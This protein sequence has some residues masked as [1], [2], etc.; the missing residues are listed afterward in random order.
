MTGFTQA[1][2][3]V[4]DTTDVRGLAEFYRHLLGL[5]YRPGDEPAAE[6]TPDDVDWLVLTEAVCRCTAHERLVR[7]VPLQ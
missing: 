5:Q 7:W 6:G 4:L 3:T 2:H 1:P